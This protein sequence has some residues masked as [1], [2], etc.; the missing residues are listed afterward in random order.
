MTRTRSCLLTLCLSLLASSPVLARGIGGRGSARGAPVRLETEVTPEERLQ[1]SYYGTAMMGYESNYN[2]APRT[3]TIGPEGSALML[4]DLGVDLAYR[5]SQQTYLK[6]ELTGMTRIPFAG[7]GDSDMLLELPVLLL[8]R[9]TPELELFLSSHT[10]FERAR[11]SPIGLDEAIKNAAISSEDPLI[12]W[13]IYEQL[14]PAVT[15]HLMPGAFVEAGPY[16]RVKQV[17]FDVN[18]G[19]SD[20]R[21][22]DLGLDVSGKYIYK[23]TLAARLR[24]DF[25]YRLF[26]N[27]DARP[28]EYCALNSAGECVVNPLAGT[29]LRMQRHLFGLYLSSHVWGPLSLDGSYAIRL[30]RD[31]GGFLS[32]NEHLIGGGLTL[33]WAERVTF[34]GAVYF[35]LRNY[36][37]RTNCE[38]APCSGKPDDALLAEAESALVLSGKVV[39]NVLE[40]LQ[41]IATY[42]L[43]DASADNEDPQAPLHR[44]LGGAALMF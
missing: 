44:I 41:A 26:N 25:A 40:W 22:F 12:Y 13:A 35:Q 5:P 15:Y 6:G 2:F 29:G 37:E 39:V 20:Y 14:R 16:F 38:G 24:Y 27:Y 43:E 32:Y 42:E 23:R 36:T 11:S 30:V 3:S 28:G 4:L 21:L 17:N 8:H 10:A 18:V 19:D 31:N 9:L 1:L 34:A 33:S 7:A